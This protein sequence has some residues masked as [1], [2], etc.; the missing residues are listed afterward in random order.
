MFCVTTAGGKLDRFKQFGNL[1][2]LERGDFAMPDRQ[3]EY[4]Q[5]FRAAKRPKMSRTRQPRCASTTASDPESTS[6]SAA[7]AYNSSRIYR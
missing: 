7:A 5:A 6:A 4:A 1:E 2:L 3:H